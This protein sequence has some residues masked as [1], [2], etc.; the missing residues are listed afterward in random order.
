MSLRPLRLCIVDMNNAHVNQAMR[1]LR[2]LATSVLM[3]RG[4]AAPRA[5]FL[6]ACLTALEGWLD[7]HSEEGFEPVRNA[8]RERSSTL[9]QEVSVRTEGRDLRG[10]AL[11]IDD[12]GAL[13]VRTAQGME[14]ILSGDVVHLRPAGSLGEG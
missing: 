4:S 12:S 3:E 1:C 10:R 5:L 11:D 13:L 6:A 2:G 9:G 14:R 8:W 7:R